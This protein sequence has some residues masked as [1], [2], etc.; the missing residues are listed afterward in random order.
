MISIDSIHILD[1]KSSETVTVTFVSLICFHLK[2]GFGVEQHP[3]ITKIM[4][5]QSVVFMNLGPERDGFKE[6]TKLRGKGQQEGKE[7]N[8]E[9]KTPF[10]E[11]GRV[12]RRQALKRLGTACSSLFGCVPAN[13]CQ[14]RIYGYMQTKHLKPTKIETS[15][16]QAQ[17]R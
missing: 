11:G 15:W 10:L 16:E 7:P 14:S 2:T 8:Q 6:M 3:K 4:G 12:P 13:Q 17:H 9:G 1:P 5:H